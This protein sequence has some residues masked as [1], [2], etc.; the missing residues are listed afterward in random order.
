[1]TSLTLLVLLDAFRPDYLWRTDFLR[2]LAR[3]AAVGE[4]EEPFGFVPRA[5]YFG[6]LT[7]NDTGVSNLFVRA[8]WRSPFPALP[9]LARLQRAVDPETLRARTVAVAAS[10][11][12]DFAARYV[13]GFAVPHAEL[14]TLALAET[15][16][17]WGPRCGYRSLFHVLDD[18]GR[19]W[20]QVSWPYTRGIAAA[21]AGIVGACLDQLTAETRFA[22]VHLSA[23][24][25]VG[26]VHGPGSAALQHALGEIDRACATLFDAAHERF[27]R[28]RLLAFGDHGMVQVV[29]HHDLAAEL[30]TVDL[31]PGVDYHVFVD[32]PMARFWFESRRARARMVAHL[33]ASAAGTVLSTAELARFAAERMSPENGEL[34]FMAHPGVVFAPNAFQASGTPV[35][36]MHGY[37][38]DV[39]DNRGLLLLYDSA[40]QRAASLGVAAATRLF[41]TC[42]S[43]CDIAPEPW[44]ALPPLRGEPRSG[45]WTPHGR[46]DLEV[47][48]EADVRL[49]RRAIE[50][51]AP[52]SAVVV[53][54]SAGRGEAGVVPTSDG[55]RML[56]DYDFA[57]IGPD[58]AG[59]ADLG[60]A[61][62]AALGTDFCDVLAFTTLAAPPSQLLFD[63]RYGGQVVAGDRRALD[64]LPAWAPAE[65]PAR[66]TARLLLNRIVGVMLV[67]LPEQRG[68]AAVSAFAANQLA[69]AFTA[70]GD[71]HLQIA[72]DYATRGR[73]R[74]ARLA[75]L[76]PALGL[77]PCWATRIDAAYAFKLEPAAAAAPA[78]AADFAAVRTVI[79]DAAV[80]LA[81]DGRCPWSM[82]VES[83]L[84]DEAGREDD[85]AFI[86]A[87]LRAAG[88]AL[89]PRA[90]A[91]RLR[92]RMLDA[93]VALFRHGLDGTDEDDV[94]ARCAAASPMTPRAGHS[95]AARMEAARAHVA[96][97]WL[98]CH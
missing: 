77:D 69:K 52:A 49:A 34:F 79:G 31:V 93:L 74:R 54:G 42:L 20:I 26:H 95:A 85:D 59:A 40:E 17:P 58:A 37:R 14:A 92:Q 18:A 87:R 44:T 36:G 46:A 73:E 38:P 53:A 5:A 76:A 70:A 1:M 2:R 47:R 48:V 22:F 63:L 71:A 62:A 89:S 12:P 8:P 9:G 16:P 90:R 61:L 88:L 15:E 45:R 98:A 33:A 51:R 29:R 64:R 96:A 27:D 56:N 97:V 65:I 30:R 81:G 4:M 25:A 55:P 75:A 43:L 11:L 6:G 19:R 24:D 94:L 80:R 7:P 60:P 86:H 84:A 66:D 39:A 13:E 67:P 28:V 10:R 57:V 3:R 41:P 72:G 91:V 78:G 50:E 68:E 83:A 21:D 32:S 23:L 35:R 82:L